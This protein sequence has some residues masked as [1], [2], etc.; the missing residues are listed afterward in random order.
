MTH[1]IRSSSKKKEL[2]K[3]LL[4]WAI[5][6][7]VF[8]VIILLGTFWFATRPVFQIQGIVVRGASVLSPEEIK[9][10]VEKELSG[11]AL[12]VL[13]RSN[14][15]LYSKDSVKRSLSFL[16]PRIKTISVTLNEDRILTIS[17]SERDPVALWCGEEKKTAEDVNACYYLDDG[18]FIFGK[19]PVF[20]GNAYFEFFGKGKLASGDP[21]G[22]VFISPDI[23]GTIFKLRDLLNAHRQKTVSAFLQDD[24][25]IVLLGEEG[26][27]IRFNSDQETQLLFSNVE[28]VFSSNDWGKEI[29]RKAGVSLCSS[30]EY[31]DFRFG[32]KI[33]FREKGAYTPPK[34]NK[35]QEIEMPVPVN[36]G[37]TSTT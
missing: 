31:I 36:I 30:L 35:E 10:A 7:F 15:F 12:F 28:A 32:N 34:E 18:G 13:P 25:M 4:F 23:F 29:K 11:K 5:A 9:T 21:V 8:A 14:V 37:T 33:Y 3:K 16:F 1:A 2:K 27:D 20:S 22:Q 24:G 17:L 26:C 19:A 6:F